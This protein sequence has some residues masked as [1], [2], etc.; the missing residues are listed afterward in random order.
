MFESLSW[1]FS[2]K[3]KLSVS[4]EPVDLANVDICDILLIQ[5]LWFEIFL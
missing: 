1:E 5:E 2:C 4:Y 3:P